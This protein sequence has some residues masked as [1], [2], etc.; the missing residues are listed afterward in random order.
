MTQK[1][2]KNIGEDRLKELW[3][4]YGMYKSAE[5]LSVEMQHYVSFSTMRY[6]SQI[7][8]WQRPV[9]KLSPLYKGY[10]AGNVDPSRYK[11]LIFPKE[12]NKNE[13]NTISE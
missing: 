10:L 8:N 1:L 2:L 4:R 7:K 9:N 11:Q 12:E 3:V 5:L 13:H 6:L